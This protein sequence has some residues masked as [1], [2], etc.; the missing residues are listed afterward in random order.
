MEKIWVFNGAYSDTRISEGKTP[1]R[2]EV[3]IETTRANIGVM[4][5]NQC[6]IADKTPHTSRDFNFNYF[7]SVTEISSPVSVP[8]SDKEKTENSER[9]KTGQA[10]HPQKFRYTIYVDANGE[11]QTRNKLSD[12]SFS[13]L[14]V[15]RYEHPYRQFAKQ[16]RTLEE[17]DYSTIV[18][19]LIYVARTAFGKLVNALPLQNRLEFRLLV[20]QHFNSDTLTD[21]DYVEALDFLYNYI[22]Q[23]IL[24]QGRLLIETDRLIQETFPDD[25]ALQRQVGFRLS[26]DI[27]ADSI[28]IQADRFRALFEAD[29]QNLIHQ[30][31]ESVQQNKK[32]ESRFQKLFSRRPL[33][34]IV[35]K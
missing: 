4:P 12:L 34:I 30:I 14:S 32:I 15:D 18:K 8:F 10:P 31:K 2:V 7:G 23:R 35:D 11:L 5:S 21:I 29:S 13:L 9:A 33:P 6:L 16:V 24:S 26:E 3:D 25:K 28:R 22:D 20:I 19:G 27:P 1:R 17:E